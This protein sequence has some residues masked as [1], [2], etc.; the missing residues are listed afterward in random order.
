MQYEDIFRQ[1]KP[2]SICHQQTSTEG[3]SDPQWKVNYAKGKKYNGNG[4]HVGK[5]K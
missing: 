3:D 1:A 2:E 4:K 5:F